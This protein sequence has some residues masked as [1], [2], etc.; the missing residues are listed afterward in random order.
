M[1]MCMR[2]R[3]CMQTVCVCVCVCV[4]VLMG[5]IMS[6]VDFNTEMDLEHQWRSWTELLIHL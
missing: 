1:C 5:L 2:M 6:S 3:M 4:C